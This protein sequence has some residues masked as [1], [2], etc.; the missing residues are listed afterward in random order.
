[1]SGNLLFPVIAFNRSTLRTELHS[2][3]ALKRLPKEQPFMVMDAAGN[4]ATWYPESAQFSNI[5][6]ADDVDFTELQD[7]VRQMFFAHPNWYRFLYPR[8]DQTYTANIDATLEWN[9]D[10]ARGKPMRDFSYE[11]MLYFKQRLE[12]AQHTA[13]LQSALM[14]LAELRWFFYK[15][16]HSFRWRSIIVC[17]LFGF[18]LGIGIQA[19]VYSSFSKVSLLYA[20]WVSLIT[21]LLA[22]QVY[23]LYRKTKFQRIY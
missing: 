20:Y 2:L 6:A 11:T 15:E 3:A 19:L 12:Q 10:L 18:L 9:L 17:V 13:E 22:Q 23:R 4:T 16:E 5:T 1:M 14:D 8:A 7:K 21:L